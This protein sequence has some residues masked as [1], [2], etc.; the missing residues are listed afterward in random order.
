NILTNGG[1][2]LAITAQAATLQGAV[3]K[4]K[5]ILQAISFEGMYFRK[6]IGYEFF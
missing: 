1:R 3:E 5:N 2:V 6:D 4:S